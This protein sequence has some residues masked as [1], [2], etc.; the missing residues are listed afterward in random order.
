MTTGAP[1]V[2][3]LVRAGLDRRPRPDPWLRTSLAAT[4]CPLRV[5]NKATGAPGKPASDRGLVEIA[6]ERLIDEIA[7]NDESEHTVLPQRSFEIKVDGM[8]VRGIASLVWVGADGPDLVGNVIP[9][10]TVNEVREEPQP[11]H[12]I[13]AN[14]AAYAL[15]APRWTICYVDLATG[16]LVEHSGE[17]DPIGAEADLEVFTDA[18]Y[19]IRNR[20]PP[21]APFESA[22]EAACQKCPYKTSCWER[23]DGHPNH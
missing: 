5:Y 2:R 23:A 17:S 12:E 7:R 18:G 3:S 22:S 4:K 13:E 16:E 10:N 20:T 11:E 14:L 8:T 9:V 19:W 15:G 6:I 21:R 1:S